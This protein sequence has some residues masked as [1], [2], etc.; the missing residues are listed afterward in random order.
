M[1]AI[2]PYES[3]GGWHLIGATPAPIFDPANLPPARFAAGDTV[4][5]EP[6]TAAAF[7]EIEAAV[8]DGSYAL[9]PVEA[10]S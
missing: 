4:A 10:A 2:Y 5:F 3:P 9:T 1:T 6:I 7:D 8:A